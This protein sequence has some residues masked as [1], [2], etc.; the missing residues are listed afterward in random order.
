MKK[1]KKR[2]KLI[3]KQ[4][5]SQLAEEYFRIN[6]FLY[7]VV[8]GKDLNCYVKPQASITNKS[9]SEEDKTFGEAP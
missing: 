7:I 2:E 1:F 5:E 9:K 3:E 6:Y 8:G 4:I